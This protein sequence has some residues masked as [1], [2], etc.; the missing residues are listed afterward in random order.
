MSKLKDDLA[1][2]VDPR[3]WTQTHPWASIATAALAGFTAAAIMV[4]SKEQQALR[5]L[6][7]IEKALLPKPEEKSNG[8][9]SHD[10]QK[11]SILSVVLREGFSILAPA[12]AS[13]FTAKATVDATNDQPDAEHS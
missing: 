1:G 4:P 9:T 8:D 5:R 13:M 11:S 2:G 12:I 3:L 6:A 10:R 7:A